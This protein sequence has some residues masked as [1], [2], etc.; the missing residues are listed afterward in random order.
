MKDK[1]MMKMQDA[2]DVPFRPSPISPNS[3]EDNIH[4]KRTE[5]ASHERLDDIKIDS[6]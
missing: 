2:G 3:D 5:T 1:N 6:K 4:R